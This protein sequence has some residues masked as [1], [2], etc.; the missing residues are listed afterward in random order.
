MP[1]TRRRSC[2][3]TDGYIADGSG[4]NLFIVKDGVIYTPDLSASILPGIT[5]DSIIQIAQDL[6]HRVV[7]KNLIRTD[8]Y[9]ADEVF[10]CGTA[11]EVTP[12][13]EVDD[14]ADRPARAG[15]ARDPGGVPRHRARPQRAVGAVAR[16]R[17]RGEDD[18]GV[19]QEVRAVPLSGPYLDER[20]EELVLEVLRSGRLSL[21]P[22]IDRFEEVFAAKV[23]VPYAAAVSSGT[24]GL[25]LL[26]ISAGIGAGD[27]VITSPYSFAASA[28]C[29]IYEGGVPVFADIDAR[30]S[31]STLRRSRPRSRERT[32]AIVAVDI[33][34]YPCELDPLR[35]IAEKHGLAFIQDSCEAL[36]AEYKGAPLGSHGP[37][38]GLRVLSEQADDDG[39][40][41]DGDDALRGGVA[42][43]ALAAQPGPRRLGRLA[44]ARPAR[45]QLPHGRR[46]RGA[47]DR[48]GREARRD[49]AA[50]AA[51]AERYDE[52]LAGIDGVE[53]PC[54]DD[55][56]HKRSWFVYVVALPDNDARERVIAHFE[57]EGI[58]F[59]R[60]LPSI[61]LQPY[62]RERYG[63]RRGALPGVGGRELAAR[64]RSRS[65][66]RSSATRR[67]ASPR[68]SPPRCEA[69]LARRASRRSRRRTARRSAS[70]TTPRCRASPRRRSSRTRRP[71]ATTTALTEEIY[72]VMKGS[73]RM[74]V[75]GED[76]RSAPATPCSSRPARGTRS[77]TT[78]RASCGSSAAARRR[79]PTTTRSSSRCPGVP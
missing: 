78:A 76:S 11:A 8:L 60:Y 71:S 62:M 49:P 18:E 77:R 50:A 52:L 6:G 67:S 41:R 42:A 21:G 19:K 51:V 70:C 43:A 79:T 25:H 23:G 53:L 13:R 35:A 54:A 2:S 38:R 12:I 1:A 28:N 64:S 15:D 44:R 59:N 47:R 55:A 4:E 72:F 30:T 46:Q 33:Y 37:P 39:R 31:T 56:E 45:L 7:E 66:P 5:R 73:G 75:D 74:E 29:F 9:L 40:G 68:R 24:A 10:M 65:S 27:E 32:K 63:F 16:V 58:G 22:T 3:R 69:R 36:G 61:H 26:C 20:E 17:A 34:G 14:H 48:A 57:R